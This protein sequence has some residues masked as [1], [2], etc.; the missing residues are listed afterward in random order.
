MLLLAFV[1]LGIAVKVLARPIGPDLSVH[2]WMVG[3]R[4]SLLTVVAQ[5]VT[6]TGSGVFVY[7]AAILAAVALA[8]RRR[9]VR[10]SALLLAIVGF[11]AAI[12]GLVKVIVGRLRPDPA[13][14]IGAAQSTLSFPSGHTSTGTLLVVSCAVALG[15]RPLVWAACVWSA[16]IGWSRLYLGYHWTTDL[17]G[18]WLLVGAI[19]VLLA[20][21]LRAPSEDRERA[22]VY[23]A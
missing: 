13:Q 9:D 22:R 15:Y 10:R 2:H 16:A 14:V 6:F 1:L 17:A 11:G 8:V 19:V 23:Q 3:H 21:G 12:D 18:S 5:V 7:P 4:T 20:P